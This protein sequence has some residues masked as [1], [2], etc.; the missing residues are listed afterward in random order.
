M[1]TQRKFFMKQWYFWLAIAI[2][3]GISILSQLGTYGFLF[4]SEYVGIIVGNFIIVAMVFGLIELVR[5]LI[6]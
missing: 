2:L 4:A 3:T 6:R 1:K 5:W